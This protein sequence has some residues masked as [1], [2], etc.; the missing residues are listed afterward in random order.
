M[1]LFISLYYNATDFSKNDKQLQRF[2][3]INEFIS[4][5]NL[6]YLIRE[7]NWNYK[8]YSIFCKRI[9]FI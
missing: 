4:Q 6:L 5:K 7:V 2:Y 3:F 8:N 9:N 1:K